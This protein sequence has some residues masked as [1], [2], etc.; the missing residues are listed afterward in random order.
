MDLKERVGFYYTALQN[1][2]QELCAILQIN[3]LNEQESIAFNDNLE[4]NTL[5]V[6]YRK[7]PSKFIRSY[8]YFL[9]LRHKENLEENGNQQL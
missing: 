3:V 1:N 7:V 6:I 2:V 8:D 4:F 9:K 5:S